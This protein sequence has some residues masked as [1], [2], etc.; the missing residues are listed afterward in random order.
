MRYADV[1]DK[2]QFLFA[3]KGSKQITTKQTANI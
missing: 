1:F 3:Q 2:E